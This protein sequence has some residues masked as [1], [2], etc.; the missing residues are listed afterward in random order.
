MER[1]TALIAVKPCGCVD[2]A[3]FSGDGDDV[4]RR[5]ASESGAEVREVDRAYAKQ[6]LGTTISMDGNDEHR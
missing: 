4:F 2:G 1:S 6:V 5:L 3:S